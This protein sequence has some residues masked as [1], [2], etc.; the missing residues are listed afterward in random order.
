MR[1]NLEQAALG[2]TTVQKATPMMTYVSKEEKAAGKV[3]EQEKTADGKLR[4]EMHCPVVST[5]SGF[6]ESDV[7]AVRVAT[8]PEVTDLGVGEYGSPVFLGGLTMNVQPRRSG[9]G[10]GYTVSFSAESF[11]LELPPSQRPAPP[12]AED[13]SARSKAKAAA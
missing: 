11:S 6:V 4:W 2:I 8:A 7:L 13:T 1:I 10:K 5:A 9:D 12:K 3:S